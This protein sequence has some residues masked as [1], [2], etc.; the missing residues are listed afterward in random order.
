MNLMFLGT[1]AAEGNPAMYCRCKYCQKIRKM[2]GKNLRTRSAFRIGKR[3]QIDIGPDTYWQMTTHG[4]DMY[5]IEH[6]LITHTHSDHFQFEEIIAKNM[7]I[8][9]ETDGKILNV[10]MSLSAKAWLENFLTALYTEEKFVE[11]LRQLRKHYR[12]HELEYFKE[13]CIGDLIVKTLKTTHCARGADEKAIN[14]LTRLQDGRWLLYAL[15]TGWYPEETWAFLEGQKTDILIMDCTFG[16]RTD[17]PEYPEGHL[18][19]LSFVKMLE[20]MSAIDFISEQTQIFATHINP[21]QGLLHDELQEALDTI[22]FNVTLAYDG[23][24][25]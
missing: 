15:D 5:D 2:G 12:I 16:G 7:S 18:D 1:G 24:T 20:R 23:L 11:K 10:Y 19:M 3:H 6:I 13:Y 17:R 21:H 4:L 14:Y 22:K 9:A 8:G 25:L